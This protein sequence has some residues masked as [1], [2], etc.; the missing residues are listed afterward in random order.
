[1]NKHLI[2]VKAKCNNYYS[3]LKKIQ[4]LNLSIYDI[5]YKDNYVYLKIN[6]EDLTKLKKYLVSYKFQKEEDLGLFS[7]KKK[8]KQNHIFLIMVILGLILYS[9]LTNLIVEINVFHE[10]KRIS[11]RGIR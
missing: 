9:I 2:I 4:Y 7:L 6:N 1:M 5:E 3:F 11:K 10:N 8:I